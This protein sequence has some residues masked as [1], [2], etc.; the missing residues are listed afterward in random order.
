MVTHVYTS[1]RVTRCKQCH[2]IKCKQ[3]GCKHQP[4]QYE[5]YRFAK[6]LNSQHKVLLSAEKNKRKKIS[7]HAL[8]KNG[9]RKNTLCFAPAPPPFFCKNARVLWFFLLSDPAD[10]SVAFFQHSMHYYRDEMTRQ[11]FTCHEHYYGRVWNWF[12]ETL[13][14]L[15]HACW[16]LSVQW[17]AIPKSN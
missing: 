11:H 13:V 3:F 10:V 8:C 1:L 14:D 16:C 17:T 15:N 2:V 7:R 6:I 12:V 4:V 5:S 9:F